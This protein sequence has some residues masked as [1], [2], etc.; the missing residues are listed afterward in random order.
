[1]YSWLVRLTLQMPICRHGA[2]IIFKGR[3]SCL[4]HKA[5]ASPLQ[6]WELDIIQNKRG[7]RQNFVF[8]C[9]SGVVVIIPGRN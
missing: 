7:V 1:M 3:F 4:P 5:A 6:L 2:D 8:N 9:A